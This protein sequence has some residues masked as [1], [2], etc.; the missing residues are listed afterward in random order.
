MLERGYVIGDVA[1]CFRERHSVA[2][3]LTAGIDCISTTAGR[4]GD[5]MARQRP[6]VETGCGHAARRGG[7]SATQQDEGKKQNSEADHLD[8]RP[9]ILLPC[10]PFGQ[11]WS[12]GLARL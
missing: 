3:R 12:R 9:L 2:T 6:D 7:E 8:V 1:A 10:N 4:G 11:I 5:R